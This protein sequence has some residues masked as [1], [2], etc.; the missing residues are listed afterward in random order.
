MKEIFNNK[1]NKYEDL[2]VKIKTF[3]KRYKIIVNLY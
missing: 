2:Y 1:F 3:K